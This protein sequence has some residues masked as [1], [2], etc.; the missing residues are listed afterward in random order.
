M[1]RFYRGRRSRNL[2]SA[3]AAD[4]RLSRSRIEDFLRCPRC[5]Y[6]DLRLGV[7]S[8]PGYPFNLNSAV[9]KLL[10]KEFDIHRA[11][12]APHPLMA[13]YGV[14]AVPFSHPKIDEW[15]DARGGGITYRLEATN[16]LITGGIDDL[17]MN[18]KRELHVVDY[19]ATAKD[20]DVGI[21]ADWQVGYRRQIEIYQWLFRRNGFAVSDIGYFVY[22]NGNTDRAAFDGKL[23]FD[24][25]IIPYPGMDAW[26]SGAI[27]DAYYCLN[28]NDLPPAAEECDFCIY[29]RDVGDALKPFIISAS[30][31][32]S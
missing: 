17:W 27:Q 20:S 10:K 22:A 6:L 15:R 9:D 25:K 21:D 26:V 5:F 30:T 18:P 11:K 7:A 1:S 32:R 16:F 19:K 4:F 13:A 2:Y 29:R 12:N 28:S 31:T 8:P 23:E 24:V 3:S 14:D